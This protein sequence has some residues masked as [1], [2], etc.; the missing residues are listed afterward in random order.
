MRDGHAARAGGA[1]RLRDRRAAHQ[2][3]E[4][5]LQPHHGEHAARPVDAVEAAQRRVAAA[6][7]QLQGG[8]PALQPSARLL[9]PARRLPLAHPPHLHQVYGAASD[10]DML[11]GLWYE[12]GTSKDFRTPT[13]RSTPSTRSTPFAPHPATAPCMRRPPLPPPRLGAG[14]CE[15]P[16]VYPLPAA[17]PGFEAAYDAARAAGALPTT[18]HKTSCGGDWWQLGTCAWHTP[19][20]R[21]SAPSLATAPVPPLPPPRLPPPP[22]LLP[23][24]RLHLC[25]P[26]ASSTP[27]HPRPL[28]HRSTTA[29]PAASS[30]RYTGAAPKQLG[31]FQPTPGWEELFEQR[32]IDPGEADPTHTRPTR[33]PPSPARRTP[34]PRPR[35]GAHGAAHDPAPL[36]VPQATSTRPRTTSTPPRRA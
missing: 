3:D 24:R 35:P 10:A 34:H 12:I 36:A 27:A 9:R 23:P 25:S 15:C 5:E 20:P 31:S 29:P 7:V 2:L 13:R 11:K 30:T 6:H 33:R 19:A 21:S 28:H 16:S 18:V 22:P 14:T 17:S 1:C 26:A 32:R 8:P 4:A